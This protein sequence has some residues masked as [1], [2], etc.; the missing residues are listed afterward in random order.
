MSLRIPKEKMPVIVLTKY[1]KIV[2]DA[3]ITPGGRLLDE[4]NKG[5]N[6]IPITNAK[7]Y[8]VSGKDLI[9]T[10]DFVAVNKDHVIYI[11]FPNA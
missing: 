10:V 11:T 4:L 5:R 9:E 6:F 2:G 1:S 8:D 3:H 7:F